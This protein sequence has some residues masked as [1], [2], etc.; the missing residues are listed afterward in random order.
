MTVI[1]L[2]DQE[3]I[4][5]FHRYILMSEGV[6]AA[7]LFLTKVEALKQRGRTEADA[8][9]LLGEALNELEPDT[10]DAWVEASHAPVYGSLT[11]GLDEANKGNK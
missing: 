8:D 5:S 6:E 7:E 10:A 11:G 2:N 9:R 4:D 3:K 1:N